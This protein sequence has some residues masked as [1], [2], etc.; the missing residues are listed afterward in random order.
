MRR[1]DAIRLALALA[2]GLALALAHREAL[3]GEA[4]RGWLAGAGFWAPALF[5][6]LYGAATVLFLPG[7]VLTRAVIDSGVRR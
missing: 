4:L 1:G 6:A 3:S 7:S 2:A 5:V